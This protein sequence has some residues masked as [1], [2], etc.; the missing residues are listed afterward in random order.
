V[1]IDLETFFSQP[2]LPAFRSDATNA[3]SGRRGWPRP[4][5]LRIRLPMPPM[6]RSRRE[7]LPRSAS[8]PAL[9]LRA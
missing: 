5:S 1:Q 6:K 4:A 9:Q 2:Q 7:D 8:T 3:S